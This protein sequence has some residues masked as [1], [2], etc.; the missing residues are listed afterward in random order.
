MA[1][2]YIDDAQ[3]LN[4]YPGDRI[5]L[6]HGRKSV[7]AIVD[8]TTSKKLVGRGSI[9]IF[10]EVADKLLNTKVVQVT[11]V[12]K[13]KS[14]SYIKKKLDGATLSEIE[15]REIIR[16][17]VENKISEIEIAFF[18]A[19]CYKN[20]NNIQE[21][22]ELTR[23]MYTTGEILKPK[24]SLVFDK[25]CIG[26]IP[27]NRTTPIVISICAAAGLT[28]PKTS[29]RSITSPAGTADMMEVLCNVSL[30]L[31]KMKKIVEKI[32]ACLVWG[33]ALNLAPADDKIIVAERPLSID[34]ESQ[35]IASIM[36]KKLSVSANHILIDI[37]VADDAKVTKQKGK[38]LKKRF[39]QIAKMFNVKIK[40][41]LTDGSQPIGNGIG[42]SLEA[43][44]VL[45]VFENDPRAPQD[46][47]KKSVELAGLVLEMANKAGKGKGKTKAQQIL[48]SGKAQEKFLAILKEQ[49]QKVSKSKDVPIARYRYDF[50]AGKDGKIVNIDNFLLAAV[51]KAAGAPSDKT[52]GIYIYKHI[53]DKLEKG[54]KLF[55]IYSASKMKLDY[56]KSLLTQNPFFVTG[57]NKLKTGV[58]PIDCRGGV[59]TIQ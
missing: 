11:P 31:S 42:P 1:V 58:M 32:N 22:Y 44:D 24:S 3:L 40:V 26:G 55:T 18:V 34:A 52:A 27:A 17:I 16:D 54:E 37:P 45:W 36:A 15:I 9:G 21:T 53:G 41:V 2:L 38:Q 50:I 43:R 33:G 47:I 5:E 12:P 59:C 49:G 25:H 56:A 7:V 20:P 4:V 23:A 29:S 14:I 10:G 51:A 35:L 48:E 28:I 30:P 39:E 46:L 8:T 6:K 19:A 57:E 13:P